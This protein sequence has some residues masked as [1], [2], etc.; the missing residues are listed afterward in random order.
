MAAADRRDPDGDHRAV[1]VADRPL[2]EAR[3]VIATRF[4]RFT[5]YVVLLAFA[6]TALY[7]LIS[8]LFL[9][10][11][12]KTDLVTGFSLPTTFSLQTFIDAWNEGDFATGMWGSFARGRL[13]D[14]R[15][16]GLLAVHGLRVRDDALPRLGAALQPDRARADL[17]LR[18]DGHPALLRLPGA[19]PDRHL[20]GADPAAD[21]PVRDARHVLDARLLPDDAALAARGGPHGRRVELPH[22]AQHP[23][24]AGAAGAADALPA[25]LHVH[26]ERVPARARDAAGRRATRRR[27]SASATSPARRAP[28]TRP[29]SPRR[30]CSW[31]PRSS[32]STSFLQRHFIRGVLAGAIKE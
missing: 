18:G 16:G 15:L 30:R 5:T 8:I 3:R 26:V 23:A 12:R 10:F 24:A 13:G 17:P 29:R 4:D 2:L 7:P 25:R 19:Q 22:P 11:H 9:A 28:A 14:G 1:A 27:R 32:S 20:L 21:R 31:R 6:A